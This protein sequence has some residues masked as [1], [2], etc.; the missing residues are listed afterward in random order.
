MQSGQTML[1]VRVMNTNLVQDCQIR[2]AKR[3]KHEAYL[4]QGWHG[5]C[6]TLNMSVG[7]KLFFTFVQNEVQLFISCMLDKFVIVV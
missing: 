7:D 4:T 1:T 6:K 2:P 3:N 5:L